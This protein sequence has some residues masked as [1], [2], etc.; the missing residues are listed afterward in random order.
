MA[1]ATDME[2]GA[3][4]TISHL[5]K[6]KSSSILTAVDFSADQ[7]KV[8]AQN[9]ALQIAYRASLTALTRL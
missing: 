6:M 8:R 3:L 7:E 4:F 2:T 5:R 9:E 1:I